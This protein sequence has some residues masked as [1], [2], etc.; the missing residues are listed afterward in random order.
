MSD[1]VCSIYA[2][3]LGFMSVFIT[4]KL[5][6]LITLSVWSLMYRF[7]ILCFPICGRPWLSIAIHL[8]TGSMLFHIHSCCFHSRFAILHQGL[9]LY[10]VTSIQ[11]REI[12]TYK[13]SF[14]VCVYSE[15]Y[16]ILSINYQCRF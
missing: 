16:V 4:I 7:L 2:N 8:T 15:F 3:M 12:K 13:L 10:K 14:L 11:K 5:I 6:Y 9:F 1:L